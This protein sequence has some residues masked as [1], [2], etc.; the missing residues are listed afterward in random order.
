MAQE[1]SFAMH[2]VLI[3]TD[4]KKRKCHLDDCQIENFSQCK[5][6]DFRDLINEPS[7]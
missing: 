4:C 7:R 5:R 3:S 1:G 2:P 6:N